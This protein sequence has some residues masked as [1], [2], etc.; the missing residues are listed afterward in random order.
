MPSH[1]GRQELFGI[2][3]HWLENVVR[4]MNLDYWRGVK[5]KTLRRKISV[6]KSKYP[7][8]RNPEVAQRYEKL[9]ADLKKIENGGV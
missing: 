8:L 7:N 2:S 4:S 5:A 6:M 3:P 9:V 1:H